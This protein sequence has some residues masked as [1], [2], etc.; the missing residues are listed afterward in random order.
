MFVY[1]IY[2][3]NKRY[4]PMKTFTN[5]DEIVTKREKFKLEPQKTTLD[6]LKKFARVYQVVKTEG[7]NKPAYIL[8]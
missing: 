1:P 4:L 7:L 2:I 5:D 6:F 3:N 8:N